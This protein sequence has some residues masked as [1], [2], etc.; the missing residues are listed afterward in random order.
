MFKKSLIVASLALLAIGAGQPA[1]AAPL[2]LEN[3]NDI[4][5]AR[6][7]L[8][9]EGDKRPSGLIDDRASKDAEN[10]KTRFIANPA[11]RT[12][13]VRGGDVTQ[14]GG[15]VGYANSSNARHPW[16][17]YVDLGI[18]NVDA[19][20]GDQDYFSYAPT[21]K[22]VAFGGD[23]PSGPIVSF[24]GRWADANGLGERWDAL[25]AVD[26]NLGQNF[27]LTANVGWADLDPDAGNGD[28]DFVAGVGATWRPRQW[29]NFA[30]AGNYVIDNDVDGQDFWGVNL[31]YAPDAQSTLRIGVGKHQTWLFNW[32]WKF[33]K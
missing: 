21:F 32:A 10:P 18:T 27:F 15:S 29:K 3:Y 25:L 2:F 5:G 13:N 1:S 8:Q 11:L 16:E 19:G 6:T 23:R 17:L 7:F 9:S 24:V 14:Y 33:D 22:W 20:P 12:T 30:I 31:Q 28:D 26:Q 4:F